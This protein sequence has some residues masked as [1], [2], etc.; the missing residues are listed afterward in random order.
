MKPPAEIP[1]VRPP[2]E[3][4]DGVP[5][6][7]RR[8]DY[9]DNYQKIARDHLQSMSPT[10]ENPFIEN[11]LWFELELSTRTLVEKYVTPGSRILDV[12]VGLGRVIGP[13]PQYERYGIDISLDYLKHTRGM[14]IA[15]AY[16]LAEDMPYP[17]AYFDAVVSC[18]VLEHVQ[19]Y[20]AAVQ[21]ILR[22]LKPGGHLIL[23]VPYRE[24]LEVYLQDGLAYEYIHLRNFDEH[25]L[26][27]YFEKIQ[28]CKL[29]ETGLVSCY[30]QGATRLRNRP[31]SSQAPLRRL[32]ADGTLRG[33]GLGEEE[34]CMLRASTA[35][36][37]EGLV[38]FI[39]RIKEAKPGL[40]DAL[41]P[42]LIL[43]IEM[44]AVIHKPHAKENHAAS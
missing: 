23:R 12:G 32:L 13:L 28:R 27:L 30:W 24:D 16:A 11:A 33:L 19:G 15:V 40:F 43:E 41:R 6:F 7:S 9:T 14:E 2:L 10:S 25:S 31:A 3:T 44:N 4:V 38:A 17:D 36:T 8:S 37:E 29:L 22:V 18:D 20:D 1:F 42:H 34:E 26:R 21:Q 5:V 39:N 35:V